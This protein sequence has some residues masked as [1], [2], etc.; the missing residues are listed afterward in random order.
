MPPPPF[1]LFFRS[2]E[3]AVDPAQLQP[4]GSTAAAQL[5]AG[6]ASAKDAQL[7]IDY[8]EAGWRSSWEMLYTYGFV[9][10]ETMTAWLSAG[11]RP[12][13]F[14]AVQD[15]DPLRPQKQALL[16]ALGASENA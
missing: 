2:W 5:T 1:S 6:G 9:P 3:A 14:P 12:L 15:D 10:G 4:A 16:A 13:F 7:F 8:G 11:G